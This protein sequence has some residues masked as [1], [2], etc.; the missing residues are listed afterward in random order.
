M[1]KIFIILLI[2]ALVLGC[3]GTVTALEITISPQSPKVGE[4]VT[5]TANTPPDNVTRYEWSI[6]GVTTKDNQVHHSFD[7]TVSYTVIVTDYKQS[8]ELGYQ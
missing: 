4:L 8:N 5:F 2:C 1:R 6:Q 3:A 7:K